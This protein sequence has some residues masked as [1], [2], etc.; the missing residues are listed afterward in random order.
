[1]PNQYSFKRSQLK[2][3]EFYKANEK[4]IL[5]AQ[6]RGEIIDDIAPV[7]WGASRTGRRWI[8]GAVDPT[9]EPDAEP[10]PAQRAG[11]EIHHTEPRHPISNFPP[12]TL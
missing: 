12:I 2:N 3:H 10:K 5:L 4:A 9:Q 11:A 8:T 6:A 1:M 7:T